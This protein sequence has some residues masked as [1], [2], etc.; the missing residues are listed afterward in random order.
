MR[1]VA[2]VVVIG[3]CGG[4]VQEVRDPVAMPAAEAPAPET[5]GPALTPDEYAAIEDTMRRK[6]RVVNYCYDDELKRRLDRSFQGR[7]LIMLHIGRDG[8]PTSVEV[9]E[10]TLKAPAVEKCV[11]DT[12]MGFDFGPLSAE[13]HFVFPLEFA[14]QY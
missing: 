2:W 3:A 9:K 1:K 11:A 6:A 8:H 13:A 10:S 14:P 7:V 12:I 4:G 5:Q